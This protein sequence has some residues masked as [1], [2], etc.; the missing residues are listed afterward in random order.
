M[1]SPYNALYKSGFKTFIPSLISRLALKKAILK[2]LSGEINE[3]R[4]GVIPGL[5]HLSL[6]YYELKT[7]MITILSPLYNVQNK[8]LNVRSC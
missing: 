1:K 3:N 7:E 2:S 6:Y 8:H 5:N 4:R